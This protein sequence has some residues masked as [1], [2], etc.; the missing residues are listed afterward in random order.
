MKIG[1]DARFWSQTG[2]GRYIREIVGELSRL[3]DKNDYVVYLMD[4]DFDEVVLPSNFRK[5]KTNI[6]WH[7]LSEQLVL[8]FLYLKEKFNVLLVLN[9]NVPVLYPG[10]FIA[11]VHDLT[12]LRTRTGSATQLPYVLYI[13]KYLAGSLTHYLAVKRS[14]KIFTVSNYVKDDLIKTFK[15]NPDKIVLTPNAVDSNFYRRS[16][17]E[18]SKILKRYEITPPYI[19]YVGNGCPHKNL[20][21]LIN[22]FEILASDIPDLTLVLGGKMDFN[23]KKLQDFC[24]NLKARNRIKF[25][26]YV[27][28]AELPS[29]YSGAEVYVNP[30]MYEGFGIQ[31][32]EAFACGCKVA[33]SDT[34]SLPEVGEDLADYFD[35]YN[36]KDMSR[37]IKAS[38]L[39]KSSD[40]EEKALARVKKYSWRASA[41]AVL[42]VLNGL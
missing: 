21:R 19:F 4:D 39:K 37:V 11:T 36:E 22:A 18:V 8:P 17:E 3:D 27:E 31:I 23:Y 28:E 14:T 16:K 29:L 25:I 1:I 6:R 42:D 5:V 38:M 2:V 34:T 24:S 35:P 15:V 30:S 10:K 7:T 33:C 40:F 20:T 9:F 41:Q 12:L 32:L 26:G 13:I